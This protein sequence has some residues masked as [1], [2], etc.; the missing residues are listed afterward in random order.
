MSG[1]PHPDR[2]FES[3]HRAGAGERQDDEQ[4]PPCCR[5]FASELEKS[6]TSPTLLPNRV[7]EVL[8]GLPS[9]VRLFE[10]T[11]ARI[12]NARLRS[13]VRWPAARRVRQC[14]QVHAHFQGTNTVAVRS[15][16]LLKTPQWGSCSCRNILR[17]SAPPMEPRPSGPLEE[18]VMRS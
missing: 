9:T 2:V 14:A 17:G 12:A 11:V 4:L 10:Q 1:P 6:E 5:R 16:P 3:F 8:I 13:R 15:E 18:V 7:E